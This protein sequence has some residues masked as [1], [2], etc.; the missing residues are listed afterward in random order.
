MTFIEQAVTNVVYNAIRYNQQGGH[1]A[2]LLE[3]TPEGMFLL[4]VLD[5]GTGIPD[6]DLQRLVERFYRGN[7]ARKRETQG[8]GL[9]LN[10]AYQL[11]QL[12][13]WQFTL[14]RSEFGGL[15]VDFQ[16]SWID[17]ESVHPSLTRKDQAG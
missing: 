6:E 17:P 12:H 16:G 13:H 4:R 11:A 14:I 15:Q 10:I 3:S 9:G 2:V 5:D 7:A 1:V 8:Q